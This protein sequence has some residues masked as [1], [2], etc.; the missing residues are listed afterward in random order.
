MF[1]CLSVF[2]PEGVGFPACITGRMTSIQGGP[3]SRG[4]YIWGSAPGGV[5]QN[6]LELGKRAVCIL[7]E[8]FLVNGCSEPKSDLSVVVDKKEKGID[9]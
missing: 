8:C 5:G 4:V 1:L 7:L 2:S 3:G 9:R 6:P